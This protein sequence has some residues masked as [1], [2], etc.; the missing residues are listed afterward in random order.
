MGLVFS[1]AK[2]TNQPTNQ[3]NRTLYIFA[4]F[5]HD[6]GGL[7]PQKDSLEFF[8]APMAEEF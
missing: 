6:F 4:A 8:S 3:P 7:G 1:E 2:P 5:H